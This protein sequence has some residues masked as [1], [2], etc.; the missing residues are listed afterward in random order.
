VPPYPPRLARDC[1]PCQ[2]V[3]WDWGR[4]AAASGPYPSFPV[5]PGF[6]PV[7]PFR[8]PNQ[9]LSNHPRTGM[10]N[11]LE[12]FMPIR[13]RSDRSSSLLPREVGR[14]LERGVSHSTG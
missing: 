3:A 7:Q 5:F 13:Q 8:R 14:E 9:A 1:E 10:V 11:G 12:V 6:P 2:S 4:P